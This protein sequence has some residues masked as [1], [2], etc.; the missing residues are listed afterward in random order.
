MHHPDLSAEPGWEAVDPLVPKREGQTFVRQDADPERLSVHYFRRP[1]DGALVAKVRFGPACQGPPGHAHGGSIAAV[2]DDAMGVAAWVQGHRVVA[3]DI[4]VRFRN[5]VPLGTIA[6]VTTRMDR[7]DSRYLRMA[8]T[9]SRA[10]GFVFATSEG[11]FV[12]LG[13]QGF[14]A[15]VEGA[16]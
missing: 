8:A 15:F 14:R 12:D 1:E 2:L 7:K 4:R 3:G 6:T 5:G 13:E 16:G 10:D 11:I 9:L